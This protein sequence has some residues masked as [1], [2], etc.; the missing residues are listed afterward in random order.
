MR[1]FLATCLALV[2]IAG[3]TTGCATPAAQEHKGAMT[4]AGVG[5]VAGGVIG[6]VIGHQSG[7]TTEGVLLGA[8]VGG[9]AGAAVGHYAYD[10]KQTVQQAQQQYDYDYDQNK[11]NLVRIESVANTPA[12]IKSGDKVEMVTTY[13][14][15]G[16]ANAVMDVTETR[17]VRLNGALQGK[18]SITVQRQGGTYE[19][20]VPLILPTDAAKGTYAVETTIA[21]GGSSDTRESTFVV[22]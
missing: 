6:G 19:S 11:A 18:P 10:Q 17:E 13:T 22:D 21:S 2:M 8:L 9:L 15:L 5:A 20:R 4:G 12:K 7:S 14:V 3:F 16:P 1:R